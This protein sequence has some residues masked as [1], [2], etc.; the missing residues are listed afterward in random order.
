MSDGEEIDAIRERKRQELMGAAA[1][2]VDAT[3]DEPPAAPTEPVHVRGADHFDEVTTGHDVVLVD[4]YADWCGP[5]QM[6]EPIV[7]E[8]ARDTAAVVAK[9][10]VDAH[11]DLAFDAGVRGVPT[12]LL[13]ADGEPVKRLVGLQDAAT[14]RNLVEQYA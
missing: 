8:I 9:V 1:R 2:G 6:L 7:A 11:Q 13:Y 3:G 12:L 5:C 14:L 4:Y 10:D